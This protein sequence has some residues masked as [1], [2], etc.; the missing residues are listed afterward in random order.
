MHLYERPGPDGRDPVPRADKR[1]TCHR[2]KGSIYD[3]A[4]GSPGV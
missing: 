4:N 3:T 1:L 2:T